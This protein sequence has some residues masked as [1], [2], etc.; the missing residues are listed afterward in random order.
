[1]SPGRSGGWG[2]AGLPIPA[3]AAP[4]SPSPAKPSCLLPGSA[5]RT[6]EL[7]KIRKE[8]RS[9]SLCWLQSTSG[10]LYAEHINGHFLAFFCP[11]CF[12]DEPLQGAL[13]MLCLV[14]ITDAVS[15]L[16]FLQLQELLG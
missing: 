11:F 8:R 4:T 2:Q 6:S 3:P 9:E 15:T 13:S 7:W 16:H 12:G 14:H 5:Q 10:I 1:M